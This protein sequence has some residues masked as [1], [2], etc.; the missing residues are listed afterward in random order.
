MSQNTSLFYAKLPAQ[1]MPLGQLLVKADLFK[2]VPNDWH[3]VITDIKNSTDAVLNG[4]HQNVNLIATGSIVTVLNIAFSK[5]I[6]I[7]FFFGGDGATFIIPPDIVDDV[8]QALS[9][10][11]KNTFENFDLELRSGTVSVKDIYE[12]GHHI[13]LAKFSSSRAFTVPIVLGKGLHYAEK[14]I[15]GDDYIFS[16]ATPANDIDLTGMQCRWDRIPPPED[17]EEV[18]TLLVIT[19]GD[20]QQ[21]DAFKQVMDKIDELYGSLSKRQPISIAKLKLKS[22]FNKL[23]E[24][25]RARLGK[26]RWVELINTWLLM[27]YGYIYF[28][29]RDGKNYLKNLVEM[30]D[31]LVIDGR[32]NTVISGNARQRTA[33]Q[34]FLDEMETAGQIYYGIYI[35]SASVMSCYVRDLR[36]DH[37]HFVDGS[38]GGYTQAAIMLKK[39][40]VV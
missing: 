27:L 7:P 39:K 19:A 5:N 3:V 23:G 36:D 37:I 38:E 34:Q 32:I 15:K 22:T 2:D 11:R 8:M 25:M 28:R 18:V 35:S 9:L 14:I 6:S 33:L 20:T 4:R 21:S 10:Y 31:T 30:S 29:T 12:G 26:I 24:E 1:R 16:D 17:K 40:L 13:H